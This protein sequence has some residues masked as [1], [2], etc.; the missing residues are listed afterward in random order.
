MKPLD[1]NAYAKEHGPDALRRE[2]DRAKP[3]NGGDHG[4]STQRRIKFTR[5]FDIKLSTAP[6]YLVKGILP[7]V[8]LMVVWGPPK[9][10]KSFFVFDLVAHVAADWIYRDRRV[11]QCPVVYFALE[12]QLGFEARVE[13]FRKA[14]SINDI[15]LYL[16]TDRIV[17]PQDGEAVVAS[18]SNQFPT[19][20][21]GIVVLDTLNRSMAGS[22]ND[23]SDMAAYVRTADLIRET[24]NCLV[25]II[26]H[27]GI[28]EARPRGHTSLTG[29]AD[30]QIAVS[31]DANG[32][33]VA[34]VEYMKDGAQG[35]QIV[36]FLEQ[37]TV[38][39]D[40]DGEFIT[41]LIVRPSDMVASTKGK[42][43]GQAALALNILRDTI[44]ESNEEPPADVKTRTRARTCLE[45]NWRTNCYAGMASDDATRT[46]RQKAFVRAANKLLEL[47]LIG[48]WGDHVWLA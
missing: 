14:H 3:T 26:H 45:R 18:I 29:A 4:D 21:P 30:G 34:L 16:S 42:I 35:D 24:F 5:F 1:A 9:C 46:S 23:P 11:K 38:G 41:S 37:I 28:K 36:S 12:G 48:K 43:T 40:D 6:R 27:C 44:A 15:P 33:V 8:G 20:Q 13:A 47:K 32:N 2:F 31:R 39:T 25:I 22:E 7:S 19:V 10:G 17:L